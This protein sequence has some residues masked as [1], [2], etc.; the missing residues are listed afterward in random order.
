MRAAYEPRAAANQSPCL[1]YILR[2]RL[3]RLE[4]DFFY[5]LSF[6]VLK[7]W[8]GLGFLHMNKTDRN[9]VFFASSVY[10]K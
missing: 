7:M 10:E 6:S 9:R 5:L 2:R 3:S 4:E 1:V 8:R